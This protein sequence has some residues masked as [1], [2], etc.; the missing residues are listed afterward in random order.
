MSADETLTKDRSAG[1]KA[2]P[3]LLVPAPF[4]RCLS[5]L[6]ASRP[7]AGYSGKDILQPL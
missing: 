6:L 7:G 4:N 2:G 1:E 5:L 3:G